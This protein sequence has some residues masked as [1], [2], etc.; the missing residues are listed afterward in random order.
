MD[1]QTKFLIRHNSRYL[2][3]KKGEKKKTLFVVEKIYVTSFLLFQRCF[4]NS[5]SPGPLRHGFV[6]KGKHTCIETEV[7]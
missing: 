7:S 6:V 2:P 1:L 3:M 4:R 5:S